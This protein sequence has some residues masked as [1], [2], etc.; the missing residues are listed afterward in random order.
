MKLITL[1]VTILTISLFS[2]NVATGNIELKLDLS[3]QK[4]GA[5]KVWLPYPTSNKYQDISNLK[6]EGNYKN[7]GV[8]TDK[9]FGTTMLYAEWDKGAK[10]RNLTLNYSVSREE[11][12]LNFPT[13]EKP[14]NKDDFKIFLEATKNG[15]TDGVVGDLAKEITKG[16]TT[17]YDKARAIYLWTCDNM[18]REPKTIG[19][20]EGDVCKLLET[21][22]GKCADIHSVFVALCR[23]AGVPAREVL[24]SRLGKKDVQDITGWQHCWAEFYLPGTGWITVDPG[25][26]RKL[27]LKKGYKNGDAG[28]EKLKQYF[29]GGID[30]YRY[31]FGHGRDLALEPRQE[32]GSLNYLM[33]PYAEIDGKRLNYND[34]KSFKYNITATK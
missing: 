23:S 2:K 19:C 18:Y 10:S 12:K 29:W 26:V 32:D 31:S 34:P 33:Y 3:D 1:L 15:P 24:G 22:G 5:T 14:W 11:V 30:Q 6:L 13:S 17:I 20:G 8:Y 25:D 16:K 4:N 9:K 27:M 28:A 7:S 21:P